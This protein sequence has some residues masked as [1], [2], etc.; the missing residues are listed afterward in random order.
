MFL[1]AIKICFKKIFVLKGRASR[2]EYWYYVLFCALVWCSAIIINISNMLQGGGVNNILSTLLGLIL[3]FLMIP[4]FCVSVRR[5]H[6][7]DKSGFWLFFI[8]I[9]LVGF[10]F[11]IVWMASPAMN[12][13]NQYGIE[14]ILEPDVVGG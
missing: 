11:Y 7:I 10:I 1:A 13:E 9:P 14:S 4:L 12:A 5:F 8:L 6:D 3:L 2:A